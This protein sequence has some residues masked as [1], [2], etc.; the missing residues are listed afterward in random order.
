MSTLHTT[1]AVVLRTF[2]HGDNSVVLKAYT[3]A[4]GARSYIVRVGKRSAARPA[5]LQPLARVELVVTER[6][7][8]EM[9]HVQE[10]RLEKA[11]T[12]AT[13]DQPR[14]LVLL[15]AQEVFYRTLR[16]ESP[17]NALFNCVLQLLDEID[18]SDR[19]GHLP[20]LVLVRLAK[21]IGFLPE[22]PQ[23]GDDRFDLREG[24]FFHG[25]PPHAF[26][27]EPMIALGFAELMRS[28]S[29]G[30]ELQLGPAVRKELLDQLLA[31]FRMHVEGFGQLR[32]PEV[33]HAILH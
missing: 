3:E 25:P 6:A 23:P 2:R 30:T 27:M 5:H 8:R 16:E 4:F 1:R 33:L 19:P 24:R 32:S 9:H 21:H 20:L 26:C 11:Y 31:Y 29:T 12:G 18:T 28:A 7:E 22:M 13:T 17:D 15:F 10:A 14:A